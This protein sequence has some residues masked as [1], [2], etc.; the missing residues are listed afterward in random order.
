MSIFLLKK[1]HKNPHLSPLQ[2]KIF[3]SW[4]H[5]SKSVKIIYLDAT[6]SLVWSRALMFAQI[7]A[8]N[9]DAESGNLL[10]ITMSYRKTVAQAT[11]RPSSGPSV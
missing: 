1:T 5:E 8:V 10:E 11:E 3:K 9:M 4:R 6:E 7:S 2:S